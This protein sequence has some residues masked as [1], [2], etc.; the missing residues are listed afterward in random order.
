[1]QR[2]T[3]CR[4]NWLRHLVYQDV[5]AV[6]DVCRRPV[7]FQMYLLQSADFPANSKQFLHRA[8]FGAT[9]GRGLRYVDVGF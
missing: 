6:E 9:I 5:K 3:F 8:C 7:P 1:M 4:V 2:L